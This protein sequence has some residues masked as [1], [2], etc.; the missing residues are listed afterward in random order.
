MVVWSLILAYRAAGPTLNRR[1]AP[2]NLLHDPLC[3]LDRVI[4]GAD[5][6]RDSRSSFVLSKFPRCE[7][8]GGNQEHALAPSSTDGILALSPCIRHERIRF[9]V[10]AGICPIQIVNY[11]ACRNDAKSLK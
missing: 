7:N 9:L 5:R 2:I 4:N 8:T 1:P 3:P 6:C 11:A 10:P